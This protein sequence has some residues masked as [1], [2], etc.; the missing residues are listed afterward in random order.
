M[1]DTITIA[2]KLNSGGIE[3]EEAIMTAVDDALE[4][5]ATKEFVVSQ[6]AELRGEMQTGFAELRTENAENRVHDKASQLRQL[7]WIVGT[8]AAIGALIIAAEFFA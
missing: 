3:W 5:V 7:R 2:R 1:S 6:V 4:K 8:I